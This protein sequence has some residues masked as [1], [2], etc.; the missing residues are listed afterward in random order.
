MDHS[1]STDMI[2]DM[3]QADLHQQGIGAPPLGLNAPTT[4]AG[5]GVQI[6]G[7]EVLPVGRSAGDGISL[8]PAKEDE[9]KEE[10]AERTVMMEVRPHG[11]VCGATPVY[12]R[13]VCLSAGL[14]IPSNAVL[15]FQC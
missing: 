11:F 12:V 3:K 2:T 8:E 4:A 9:D 10:E 14:I 13:A 7:G 1:R 15:G 6:M 5:S